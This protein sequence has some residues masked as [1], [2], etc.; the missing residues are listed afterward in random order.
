MKLSELKPKDQREFLAAFGA[1]PLVRKME[2][3][4]NTYSKR[5]QYIQAMQMR[6]KIEDVKA[7]VF[8]KFVA[9]LDRTAERVNLYD[10]K[11]T[12]AQRETLNALCVTLFMACDVIDSAVVDMKETIK[13]VDET[14]EFVMFDDIKQVIEQARAKIQFMNSASDVAQN[15][16]WGDTADNMYVMMQNKARSV[17]RKR[18]AAGK[19]WGDEFAEMKAR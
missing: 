16:I 1:D 15:V 19:H 12:P 9:R 17:I 3:E 14:L 18:G 13:A 2:D 8:D 4:F 10:T 7:R 6:A 11:I 5:G